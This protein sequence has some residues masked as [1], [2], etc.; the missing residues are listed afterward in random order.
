M[1][2]TRVRVVAYRSI[3]E[4]GEGSSVF[5]A[6][7]ENTEVMLG[8]LNMADNSEAEAP[9]V[10]KRRRKRALNKQFRPIRPVLL[11][12]ADGPLE[13]TAD[14]VQNTNV[15]CKAIGI[16]ALPQE[17]A[18]PFYVISAECFERTVPREKLNQWISEC[19]FRIGHVAS[20]PVMIRSSGTTETMRDR[21]SLVSVRCD[22]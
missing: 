7:T 15:G 2:T 10:R 14:A 12:T 16:N 13:L 4:N 5:L 9:G 6:R 1:E 3:V 19:S 18:P 11:I 17:W 21:G 22:P 8:L 20:A